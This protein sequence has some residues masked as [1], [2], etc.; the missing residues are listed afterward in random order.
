MRARPAPTA[1]S[2]EAS[3]EYFRQAHGVRGQDFA[4][5][6]SATRDH[7]RRTI[8]DRLDCLE[9]ALMPK[10]TFLCPVH[11][12]FEVTVPI[13]DHKDH[14]PCPWNGDTE[15]GGIKILTLSCKETTEQTY[16]PS[17]P[18]DWAIK[19]IVVHVGEGGAF[20]FPAHEN[21]P[22]PKGFNRVELKSISEIESFERKA[23][24]RLTAE[25]SI[26][27]EREEQ[28]FAKL[29]EKLRSELRQRMQ[30]MSPFGRDFAQFVIDQNNKRGRKKSD[31][32]FHVD[33]LHNDSSNRE[34]YRDE[35]TKWKPTRWI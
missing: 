31:V 6:V 26:H 18:K 33:I 20:R 35:Q 19:P 11:G 30:T 16:T 28:H 7:D 8:F 15:V 17:R 3:D 32:G 2:G 22:V 23:N 9:G 5:L 24:Q 34:P 13:S 25:A 12:E 21:A 1:K 27:L 14:W 29:Q 4:D 10:Y